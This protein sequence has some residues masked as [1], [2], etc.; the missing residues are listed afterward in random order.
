MPPF[1]AKV[2][3]AQGLVKPPI[4]ANCATEQE[5]MRLLKA[6][7]NDS[8]TIEIKGPMPLTMKIAF[9][10]VPEGSAVFRYDWIWPAT[11][12]IPSPSDVAAILPGP[13]CSSGNRCGT[14]APAF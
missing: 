2:T 7:A 8:D 11:A 14:V 5:A 12:R 3:T 10:N 1:L 6:G 9:G 13:A 4:V